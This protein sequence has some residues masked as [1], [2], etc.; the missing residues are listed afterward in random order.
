MYD[1]DKNSVQFHR[2]EA[3]ADKTRKIY[4]AA[5]RRLVALANEANIDTSKPFR[6]EDYPSINKQAQEILKVLNDQ[7]K[8]NIVNGIGQ[9]WDE[10]NKLND[11]RTESVFKLKKI[12]KVPTAYLQRNLA[13]RDA[14]INRKTGKD[15]LNLSKRVWNYVGQFRQEMEMA[16]DIGLADGRSAA[17]LS[18]DVRK[19][20]NEPDKLFRRVRDKRGVLQLSKNAK[21]YHPGRGVYRSSYKNAMRLT[22]TET[23][24]AYR[25]ADHTRWQQLPFIQGF[26][27]RL[28][29]NH[30]V[31]DI[32]D[33]LQ[34]KYPKEF[35]FTGWHPNCRCHVVAVLPTDEEFDKM[36]QAL[37][38]G[39][40]EVGSSRK[41]IRV[42]DSYKKWIKDHKTQYEEAKKKG[43]LP[44]FI[45]DNPRFSKV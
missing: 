6:F 36:E 7:I 29:N 5:I 13:A 27:V 17:E 38:D 19:Y 43:T 31:V 10:S 23:N 26:E 45:K 40:S 12:G 3:Y 1:L 34:G 25:T 30:T 39:E 28:S 4:L 33:D 21:A 24:M 18:R 16:L 41:V 9:E 14:F 20:L 15:G 2:I 32:C 22:R 8:V 11:L 44:Y 35:K 42:P 37:L